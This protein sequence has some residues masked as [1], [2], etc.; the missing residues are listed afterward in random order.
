M[1]WNDIAQYI[2]NMSP[3]DRKRSAL[4]YT[5]DQEG[6]LTVVFPEIRQFGKNKPNIVIPVA[7]KIIV[8]TDVTPTV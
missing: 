7:N 1:T 6:N 3:E 5:R 2:V 8:D 4:M